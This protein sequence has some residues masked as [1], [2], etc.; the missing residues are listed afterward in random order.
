M[1]WRW[2]L[3][4]KINFMNAVSLVNM[5]RLCWKI[6]MQFKLCHDPKHSLHIYCYCYHFY[7]CYYCCYCFCYYH[8]SYY[9]TVSSTTTTT[10]ITTFSYNTVIFITVVIPI[11]I[12]FK[13]TISVE[14]V[15]AIFFLSDVMVFSFPYSETG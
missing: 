11:A 15:I 9:M 10:I 13:R 5:C 7:C 1:K 4:M 12:I 2:K 8:C 3:F 6:T 14:A